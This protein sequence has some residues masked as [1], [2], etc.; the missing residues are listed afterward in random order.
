VKKTAPTGL[1]WTTMGCLVLVNLLAAQ[2][3]VNGFYP[4]SNARLGP[5]SLAALA[6]VTLVCIIS[7]IVGWR[8]YLKR[9]PKA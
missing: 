2:A 1:L 8:S 9:P 4:D 6:I 5:A 3:I 7:T